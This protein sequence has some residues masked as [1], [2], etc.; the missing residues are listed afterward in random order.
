MQG[1]HSG[2][3]LP[4]GQSINIGLPAIFRHSHLKLSI[5]DLSQYSCDIYGDWGSNYKVNTK[6]H[7]P[8][9]FLYEEPDQTRPPLKHQSFPKKI[10]FK[11]PV[12]TRAREETPWLL[13][14]EDPEYGLKLSCYFD[15]QGFVHRTKVGISGI[16]DNTQGGNQS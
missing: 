8:L 15:R 6:G 12:L 2:L 14:V 1:S 7:A 9:Q 3:K 5:P 13:E 16:W 11:S 10:E 4:Q